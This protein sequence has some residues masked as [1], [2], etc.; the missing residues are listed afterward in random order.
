[1]SSINLRCPKQRIIF[2]FLDGS[3]SGRFVPKT[4]WGFEVKRQEENIKIPRWAEV[5]VVGRTVKAVKPGDYILIEPMMW[6]SPFTHDF[7]KYWVTDEVKV[8]A[9]SNTRPAGIA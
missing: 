6:S 7:E 1:M 4:E 5:K 8:M 2:Q 9:T 3:E